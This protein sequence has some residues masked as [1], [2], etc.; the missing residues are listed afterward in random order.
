[1]QEGRQDRIV[2]W[3]VAA[4][5]MEIV[6]LCVLAGGRGRGGGLGG[7]G[8]AGPRGWLEVTV[9]GRMGDGGGEGKGG[10]WERGSWEDVMEG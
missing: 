10:E 1:M 2:L 4:R 5:A 9:F 6:N 8:W 3:E 7:Y